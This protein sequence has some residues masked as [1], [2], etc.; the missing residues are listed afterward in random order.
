LSAELDV[1]EQLKSLRKDS[2]IIGFECKECGADFGKSRPPRC[3]K[4]NSFAIIEIK[5]LRMKNE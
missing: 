4:C 1:E 5:R 3:P 2:V